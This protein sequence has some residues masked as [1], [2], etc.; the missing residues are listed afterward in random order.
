MAAI[1]VWQIHPAHEGVEHMA[2]FAAQVN[3]INL[4]GET[5]VIREGATGHPQDTA[6]FLSTLGGALEGITHS[7]HHD[8]GHARDLRYGWVNCAN[9]R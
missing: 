7:E 6:V 2:G 1:R 8:V 3:H 5:P 4:D 9:V